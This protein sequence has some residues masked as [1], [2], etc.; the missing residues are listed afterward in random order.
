M[1]KLILIIVCLCLASNYSYSQ[2]E[3]LKK[4]AEKAL[5][6]KVEE[7]IEGDDKKD[8]DKKE[9]KKEQKNDKKE[10]KSNTP[11]L[12]SYSKYD[13]IPGD[14]VLFFD[15]FESDEIGDYPV[16]WV[17]NSSGEIKTTNLYPGK[18]FQMT[19]NEMFA[20]LKHN[21]NLPDNFI[22]EFDVIPIHKENPNDFGDFWLNLFESDGDFLNDQLY[23]GKNGLTIQFHENRCDVRGYREGANDVRDGSSDI[24]PLKP[25]YANHVIVWVQ[26]SRVRIYHEGKK[27]IDLPS[28]VFDGTKVNR[29]IFSTWS[30][31]GVP[32]IKNIRFTTTAPDMRS[33]LL[34]E[35]KIVSH[36][37]Y[38]DVN[39]DK[40]KP[41]SAGTLKAISDILKENPTVK[42]RIVGHTDND[43]KPENN[44]TLSKKRAD[45]VKNALVKD[46][47]IEAGR[48]ETD[49]KGQTEPIEPNTSAQAKANNRRVEIIKI[50]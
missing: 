47:S 44:W 39:S 49:G 45:S 25:A 1:K 33:K 35:G 4:K 15:D 20:C 28:V 18:W 37:I 48:I 26:K 6:E 2:F 8:E 46:Y 40:I 14:K 23:P 43:G 13:F 36:G 10:N 19:G 41:E 24:S 12:Q 9:D 29:L 3:F 50:K 17:G 7:A 21:L 16:N 11:S 22:F 34:T 27:M 31:Y 42:I 5:E 32:M 30:T 38:F